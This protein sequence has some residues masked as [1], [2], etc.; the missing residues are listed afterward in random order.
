MRKSKMGS[1]SPSLG[2]KIENGN[3]PQI[4]GVENK[5][6]CELPPPNQRFCPNTSCGFRPLLWNSGRSAV[7]APGSPFRRNDRGKGPGGERCR[8]ETPSWEAGYVFGP[9]K[10]AGEKT[11]DGLLKIHGQ[12]FPIAMH[13][14]RGTCADMQK[15]MAKHKKI[16]HGLA[17]HIDDLFLLFCCFFEKQKLH[18]GHCMP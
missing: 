11:M 17:I 3:L 6:I 12:F 15:I 14:S 9:S 18:D 1:S 13:Q 16:I 4:F 2:V 8:P 10:K 5:Q 7:P